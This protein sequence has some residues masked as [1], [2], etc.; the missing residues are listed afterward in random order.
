MDTKSYT[1]YQSISDIPLKNFV[2]AAVNNNIY[3][4]VISGKPTDHELIFAW[5]KIY[6]E[7]SDCVGTGEHKL[8]TSV[9]SEV[10]YLTA[11][12]KNILILIAALAQSNE[13]RIFH[14]EAYE[15]L[16]KLLDSK[17][18]FSETDTEANEGYLKKC[19]S[20]S[21]GLKMRLDMQN[22]KL[23]SFKEKNPGGEPITKKYFTSILITLSQFAGFHLDDS[24]TVE[25]YCEWIKRF[26]SYCEKAKLKK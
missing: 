5:T 25:E 11:K 10:A 23:E 24:M 21:K 6:T 4:L 16:N 18:P 22:M 9:F 12:Y 1:Y 3:A 17:F 2:D 20:R 26:N 14:A 15:L 7:Y 13:Y 19:V 8:Y